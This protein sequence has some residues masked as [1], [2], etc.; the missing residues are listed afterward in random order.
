MTQALTLPAL[1]ADSIPLLNRFFQLS[2]HLFLSG[3]LPNVLVPNWTHTSTQTTKTRLILRWNNISVY[4]LLKNS[5]HTLAES[6]LPSDID[7]SILGEDITLAL[8]EKA[9]LTHC[10]HFLDAPIHLQKIEDT[11]EIP[12]DCYIFQWQPDHPVLSGQVCIPQHTLPMLLNTLIKINITSEQQEATFLSNKEKFDPIRMPIR[13][14]IG[15]MQLSLHT[16]RSLEIQDLLLPE[17][18]YFDTQHLTLRLTNTLAFTVKLDNNLC[19]VITPLESYKAHMDHNDNEFD[20]DF[21]KFLEDSSDMSHDDDISLDEERE[22]TDDS[23]YVPEDVD[24]PQGIEGMNIHLTFDIGYLEC[25]LGELTN[26]TP[27]FTFNLNKSIHK[28]VT[29]RANG[30]AIGK[31]ELVEIDGSIGVSIVSLQSKGS[32]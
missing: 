29:I 2:H 9:L 25:S 5:I 17:T 31:G 30:T 11:D 27:G 18:S 26:I 7:L 6:L 13:M 22:N 8:F 16:L 24:T 32:Q 21:K 1:Q 28:A 15:E 19:T 3:I 4:L 10:S 23:L 20:D 12:P 14:D